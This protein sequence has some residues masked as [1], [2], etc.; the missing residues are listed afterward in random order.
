[1]A[2]AGPTLMEVAVRTPGDFLM[3]LVNL[4]YGV[5][6]FEMVVRAALSMPLPPPPSG[7]VRYAASY[8]PIAEPG[9]VTDVR[10]LDRVTAHP[11]VVRAEVS[12][13][14]GE[15]IAPVRSSAQRVGHVLLA[16]DS[17]DELESGIAYVRD[18]LEVR[19]SERVTR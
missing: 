17:P 2:D 4:T 12:V 14:K 19:T 10:G 16:A 8:L 6:W 9:V 13:R 3:D 15:D 1:M 18:T 7:P 11:C 5:D